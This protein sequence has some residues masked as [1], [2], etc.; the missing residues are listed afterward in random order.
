MWLPTELFLWNCPKLISIL[1]SLDGGKENHNLI[2]GDTFDTIMNN[3]ETAVSDNICLYMA[4]NKINKGDLKEVCTIAKHMK[5]IRAVS[6]NFHTPYP[7][8]ESLS[9]SK[10]KR[11]FAVRR[12]LN[13]YAKAIPS[14]I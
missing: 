7:N 13:Y 10:K 3:I 4:I 11:K 12:F 1:L 14:L 2:R 8:T 6:F 5:N 9:L